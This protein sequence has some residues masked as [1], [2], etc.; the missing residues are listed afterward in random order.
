MEFSGASAGDGIT[1]TAN[2]GGI[3]IRSGGGGV[4]LSVMHM[5]STITTFLGTTTFPSPS[6]A[7]HGE[8]FIIL[9]VAIIVADDDTARVVVPKG[10]LLKGGS[11]VATRSLLVDGALS[12][13][14][15]YSFL[16]DQVVFVEVS[17]SG[18]SRCSD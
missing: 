1:N 5:G 12:F 4:V 7:L 18:S 9:V 16:G 6:S 10:V 17:L 14:K 15:I 2:A 11:D 8:F 13:G 3:M